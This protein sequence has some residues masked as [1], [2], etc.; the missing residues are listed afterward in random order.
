MIDIC[1]V[2]PNKISANT[3]SKFFFF[4]GEP[5][6]WK[7]TVA[8]QFPKSLLLGF[9]I[10][11]QFIDGVRAVPMTTWSDVKDL[12]RQLKTNKAKEMYDTIIFDTVSNAYQMCYKYTCGQLGIND[13]GEAAFGKGWRS[14]KEEFS[15]I[16]EISRLGY[17]LVF[18]AHAKETEITDAKTK[19]VTIKIKSDLDSTPSAMIDD[20]CDFVFY[21]RKEVEEDGTENVYAYSDL[22]NASTKRRLRNFPR[23]FLFSYENIEQGIKEAIGNA[24]VSTENLRVV[25][26]ESWESVRDAVMDLIQKLSGTAAEEEVYRYIPEIFPNTKISQTTALD[27]EKL[28]AARDY[29]LVLMDK[30]NGK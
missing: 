29:L 23:R 14:I 26:E 9:E 21:V 19:E 13:P 22:N 7:T 30:V 1:T 20:L 28:I 10:G 16:K 5:G 2:Q 8:S 12:Y 27:R 6:T 15:I 18:I 4:H 3:K 25:N 17:G 11:H 24:E